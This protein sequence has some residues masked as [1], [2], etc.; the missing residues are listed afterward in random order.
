MKITNEIKRI[1]KN[2]I[3]VLMYKNDFG[4]VHIATW[5]S[6]PDFDG[7]TGLPWDFTQT[8]SY[9]K[10]TNEWAEQKFENIVSMTNVEN[11]ALWKLTK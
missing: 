5:R 8:G 3:T 10:E 4:N 11:V 2:N 1:T 7:S 9:G 6:N